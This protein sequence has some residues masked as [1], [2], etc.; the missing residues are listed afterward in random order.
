M[1]GAPGFPRKRFVFERKVKSNQVESISERE[2]Q[3][4]SKPSCQHRPAKAV[5]ACLSALDPPHPA[6][7]HPPPP[8]SPQMPI[9]AVRFVA[10]SATI[11]NVRDIGDWLRVPPS[12]L[13]VYGEEMRPVKLRT[14]VK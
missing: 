4:I 5:A 2:P 11:P 7:I 3:A 1:G 9:G 8:R 13:K 12:G 14:L 10:V 6:P